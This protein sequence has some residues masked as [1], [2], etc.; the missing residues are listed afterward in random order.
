M[1]DETKL[2]L[3]TLVQLVD[4]TTTTLSY[5]RDRSK[6]HPDVRDA[7]KRLALELVKGI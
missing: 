3:A 4:A 2:Y 7:L 1:P 5:I 6:L